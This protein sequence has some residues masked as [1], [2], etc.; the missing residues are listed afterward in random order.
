MRRTRAARLLTLL[1]VTSVFALVLLVSDRPVP[2]VPPPKPPPPLPPAVVTMGDSTLAGEGG[3]NYLPGTDGRNGNWCHRSPAAP[4][5][6]LRLPPGVDRFNLACAGAKA[7]LVGLEPSPEH[8]EGSQARQLAEIVKHH[9]VTDIVVQVGANNAPNFIG[10]L[11][12]CVGAWVARKPGGCAAELRD[13]WPRRVERMQPKV[14]SALEDVRK[15]MRDAGYQR[16]DYSLVLQSYAAPVAPD[17]PAP[18]QDLSGCPLRTGDVRW[19]RGTAVPQLSRGLREAA[20]QVGARFLDLSRAGYG[21]EACTGG[22]AAPQSEWFRRL[23]VDWEALKHEKRAP[24][25]MSE[26]FHPNAAGYAQFARCLS[27]FLAT[28]ER[29]AVCLSGPL[30]NLRAV[31]P[32]VAAKRAKER[33]S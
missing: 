26:S 32:E 11:N 22:R 23:S 30:G 20:E 31:P 9:R 24:H 27:D 29:R 4:V 17:I 19:V 7:R 28:A 21:H 25:A 12:K 3:G 8:P 33:P 15:V 1:L 14:V 13:E 6:Q 18:L 5:H 10:V 2:V 16:G